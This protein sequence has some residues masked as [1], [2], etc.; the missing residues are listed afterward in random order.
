MTKELN[1]SLD[2]NKSLSETYLNYKRETGE[3]ISYEEFLKSLQKTIF[4]WLRDILGIKLDLPNKFFTFRN[5]VINRN[6]TDKN[7]YV[8]GRFYYKVD[9]NDHK[10]FLTNK[11]KVTHIYWTRIGAVSDRD[12]SILSFIGTVGHEM[13]HYYYLVRF[14][15]FGGDDHGTVFKMILSMWNRILSDKEYS[16]IKLSV[17]SHSS[18]AIINPGE[19]SKRK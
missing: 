4:L 18:I 1:I 8:A 15:R 9:H 12:V 16:Y 17:F 6:D 19:L 7:R 13:A 11:Y 5:D 2:P 14:K 3:K 10:I